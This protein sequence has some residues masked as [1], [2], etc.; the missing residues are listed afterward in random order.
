MTLREV[1]LFPKELWRCGRR[2]N[3]IQKVRIWGPFW[4]SK[5]NS[6]IRQSKV[7]CLSLIISSVQ[8]KINKITD[9]RNN[10]LM[11][12]GVYSTSKSGSVLAG[13]CTYK[14]HL[15]WRPFSERWSFNSENSFHMTVPFHMRYWQWSYYVVSICNLLWSSTYDWLAYCYSLAWYLYD[16]E[17]V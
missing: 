2:R 3:F 16:I 4:A 11:V 9:L 5:K 1:A 13:H 14:L 10:C 8:P 15:W 6:F 17:P 12:E 7:V